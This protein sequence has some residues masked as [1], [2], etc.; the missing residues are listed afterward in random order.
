MR[1]NQTCGNVWGHADFIE[2]HCHAQCAQETSP[3]IS[4]TDLRDLDLSARARLLQLLL[5]HLVLEGELL[6]QALHGVL[7]VDAAEHLL[8]E[9]LARVGQHLAQLLQLFGQVLEV[10][11]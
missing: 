10:Q 9:G 3:K 5:E 1:Q 7:H 8:L 4:L 6:A 11:R 2:R